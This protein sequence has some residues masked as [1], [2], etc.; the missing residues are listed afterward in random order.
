MRLP[1]LLLL[2]CMML[3]CMINSLW[4]ND[5]FIL[6]SSS[7]ALLFS[8]MCKMK[9]TR[10][11]WASFHSFSSLSCH[12][13]LFEGKHTTTASALQR[14]TEKLPLQHEQFCAT[15]K[16][17]LTFFL[18]LLLVCRIPPHPQLQCKHNQ[19]FS[20]SSLFDEHHR[21]WSFTS[22]IVGMKQLK[23]KEEEENYQNFMNISLFCVW[24]KKKR[25]VDWGGVSLNLKKQKL[26]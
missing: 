24:R 16:T 11:C 25:E 10:T 4:V 17:L 22:C 15:E 3:G 14:K 7:C 23:V 21:R 13:R 20:F 8:R 12:A 26:L 18:L 19:I 2:K 9:T 1:L 5:K 6:L